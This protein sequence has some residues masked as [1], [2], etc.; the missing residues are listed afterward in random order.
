MHIIWLT[1]S[2]GLFCFVYIVIGWFC[3]TFARVTN[4]VRL[5]FNLLVELK[6]LLGKNSVF[7]PNK[8]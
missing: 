6:K 1:T 5:C 7:V 3:K 2:V 8:A 4:I